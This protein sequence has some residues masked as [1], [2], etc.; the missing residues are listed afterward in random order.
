MRS[1]WLCSL[2]FFLCQGA[3]VCLRTF[4]MFYLNVSVIFV[5]FSNK[6]WCNFLYI[7]LSSYYQIKKEYCLRLCRGDGESS[8]EHEK[9]K[10]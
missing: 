2:F 3:F 7:V 9:C 1:F 4:L 6:L 10:C 5:N 8:S